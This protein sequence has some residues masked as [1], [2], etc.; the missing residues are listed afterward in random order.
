MDDLSAD[1]TPAS[2]VLDDAPSPSASGAGAPQSLQDEGGSLRDTI[3]GVMKEQIAEADKVDTAAKDAPKEEAEPKA[4]KPE[5]K[6]EPKE[7]KAEKA[8][9]EKGKFAPKEEPKAEA[10]QPKQETQEER[11]AKDK[12]RHPE[13]PQRFM[14]RAKELWP[15]VPNEVKAEVARMTQ[16]HENEVRQAR[17]FIQPLV[18]YHHI[19]TQSGT[20]LHEALDRYVNM[21][22]A[23]RS[24]PT[25]GFKALLANMEMQPQQAISH[26]LK[27]FGVSPQALAQHIAQDERSYIAPEV[28]QQ[29]QDDPRVAELQGQLAQERAERVRTSV[30]EPFMQTHPRY[31]ELEQDIAFFLQS[32]RIP[33]NLSQMERLEAAYDMAERINPASNVAP[34]PSRDT[35]LVEEARSHAVSDLGGTKS[36]KTAPGSI[37][38][39]MEPERGGSI[40]DILADEIR[41]RKMA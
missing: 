18:R 28:R 6:A 33:A 29:P 9:D 36:V 7:E 5:E 40:R 8:R 23:L 41:R 20:T 4:E 39:D 19:A 21:E 15:N 32:G 37:S 22:Q 38:P 10:E 1:I 34:A 16:D 17:E 2:T 26:I 30:I 31:Q 35:G 25:E 24:N 12:P 11:Q 27:A 14:P 13:A 3:A